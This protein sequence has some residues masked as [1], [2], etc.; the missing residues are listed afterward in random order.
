[1]TFKET[2]IYYWFKPYTPLIIFILLGVFVYKVAYPQ[3]QAKMR[4]QQPT[5]L[6]LLISPTVSASD[7]TKIINDVSKLLT[8]PTD[9]TPTI[10]AISDTKNI[11]DQPF[12][13]QAQAGDVVLLYEKNKKAIL[14]RPSQNKIIDVAA[15]YASESA[16]LKTPTPHFT[17][18]PLASPS[19]QPQ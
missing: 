7:T 5:T 1:M 2:I 3:F 15:I 11:K 18:S 6:S 16:T 17:I 13:K 4:S 9:E 8:L 14:Y 10:A 12:F 19:S